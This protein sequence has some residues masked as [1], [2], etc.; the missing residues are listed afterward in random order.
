MHT[1]LRSA[2]ASVQSNPLIA[3]LTCFLIAQVVMGDILDPR[4]ARIATLQ[5]WFHVSNPDGPVNE[6]GIQ[7]VDFLDAMK[8]AHFMDSV[9]VDGRAASIIAAGYTS[10]HDVD[11]LTATELMDTCM[12]FLQGNAKRMSS[13]LGSR[14]R[15]PS[16]AG[17]LPAGPLSLAA[18]QQYSA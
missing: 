7:D 18:S 8:E 13:Y 4:E 17:L 9:A 15:D 3:I 6:E 5:T 12:G 14:P 16:P 10:K 11:G 1:A 2:R